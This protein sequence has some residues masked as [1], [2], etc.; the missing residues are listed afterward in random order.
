MA[1]AGFAWDCLRVGWQP[2][3]W[4]SAYLDLSRPSTGVLM[5]PIG[6]IRI[7]KDS[8]FAMLLEAQRRG[9][10]LW[11]CTTPDLLLRDGEAWARLRS[12]R[13]RDDPAGWFE[14]GEPE[15]R[16]LASL[17]LFLLR[18]DPPVDEAFLHDTLVL[19]LAER[20]GLLVV[21][22]PASLRDANEKLYALHFPQCCPPTLVSRDPALLRAFVAEHGAAVLK[23]LDGMGGRSIFRATPEDPNL[24]V[25][26]ET[27]TADGTRLALAQRYIP[28]ITLGD[29]RILL[30]RGVPVPHAL[31]R[32]P[33]G[34]D[35]RG[36]M[37]RGG[38]PVAQPLSERDRWIA[39]EVAP[40]LLR[41]GLMF[42]GLDVIGDYLTEINVTS[43][44]G[45]RELDA[46]CGLNIAGSLFDALE[47]ELRVRGSRPQ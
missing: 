10:Q 2:I 21:N 13:V 35:F 28:E 18:K 25:I 11:Y 23:L 38:K 1:I 3:G 33:Q 5:D 27:L 4:R 16:P 17:D 44:T 8:T 14:L 47:D 46:Q 15:L 20:A 7:K 26:L 32:I 22:R 45:I 42:V 39:S 9:H 31:A 12:L 24:N 36:N 43:P 34:N 30:I 41:R 19:D 29:K 6:A 37:A 40:E